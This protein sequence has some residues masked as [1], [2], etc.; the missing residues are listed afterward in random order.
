LPSGDPQRHPAE[1]F[2]SLSA[3]GGEIAGTLASDPGAVQ[4]NERLI[5]Q[6]LQRYS[7]TVHLPPIREQPVQ[8]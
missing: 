1:L 7:T 4:R 8:P 6:H 2:I 3:I 5:R